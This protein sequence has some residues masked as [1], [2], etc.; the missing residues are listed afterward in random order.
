M[1]RTALAC[2]LAAMLAFAA[3]N[4]A[5]HGF[6]VWTAEGARRLEV[7]LR[8]VSAPQIAI[9][10]PAVPRRMLSQVLSEERAVTIVDFVYTRCTSVCLAL[11]SAFQRLQAGIA[12]GRPAA[13]PLRLLSISF[14]PEHDD[15]AALAKYA[16]GLRADPRVWRFARVSHLSDAKALL[17]RYQVTVIPDGLGGYEHNAALLV[18]DPAGRL[19]RVFDYAELELALAYARALAARALPEDRS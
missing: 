3:A 18:V 11:G 9:E 17:E 1:A 14:D 5:T 15:T 8:P 16:A 7:A 6:Q 10:G 13:A 19:L 2:L 4:R 12:E